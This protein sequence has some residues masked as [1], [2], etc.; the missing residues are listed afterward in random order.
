MQTV[1]ISAVSVGSYVGR[2]VRVQHPPPQVWRKRLLENLSGKTDQQNGRR[3]KTE[4]RKRGR[5]TRG[6]AYFSV[7][8]T[9]Q[10]LQLTKRARNV[11]EL[12]VELY[13]THA[14]IQYVQTAPPTSTLEQLFVAS[15]CLFG[16][17]TSHAHPVLFGDLG[18]LVLG[19]PPRD[20]RG[21]NVMVHRPVEDPG[22]TENA[23]VVGRVRTASALNAIS[24][25]CSSSTRKQYARL[26]QRQETGGP[27]ARQT[28]TR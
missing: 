17:C 28:T 15:C 27:R 12:S 21:G 23:A 8:H 18:P 16:S 3:T 1:S 19:W 24:F 2:R 22:E 6:A 13:D 10:E 11:A 26:Q 14:C 5:E 7:P 20:D 4:P 9:S 25:F